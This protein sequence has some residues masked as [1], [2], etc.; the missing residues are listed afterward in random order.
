MA[1]VIAETAE[2]TT[3]GFLELVGDPLR[4]AL[5]GELAGSDRRVGDLTTSTGKG[6]SLVSYHLGQLRAAGL[7][8]A[9]RPQLP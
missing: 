2:I 9:R 5:L 1:W 8:S 7:V 3:A 6:Q 4:W